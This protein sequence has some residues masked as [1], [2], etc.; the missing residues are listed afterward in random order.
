ME[1]EYQHEHTSS[2]PRYFPTSKRERELA[3]AIPLYDERE[4]T[5]EGYRVL[6]RR[7]R[8][9]CATSLAELQAI[10]VNNNFDIYL[11]KLYG[12]RGFVWLREAINSGTFTAFIANSSRQL[13]QL[14]FRHGRKTYKFIAV[15]NWGS[16]AIIS[17][18]F[19]NALY[20]VQEAYG[21][22]IFASPASLGHAGLLASMQA[23]KVGRVH[24][25]S[26][27]LR[28]K[29]RKY[30]SGGRA[31][32]F[33]LA[34][35]YDVAY[36]ADFDNSYGTQASLG[37]PSSRLGK[38]YC[39]GMEDVYNNTLEV[40]SAYHAACGFCQAQITIPDGF[41]G[42]FSPFYTRRSDE[43]LEWTTEPGTYTGY[44]WSDMLRRC[45]EIGFSVQLGKCWLWTELDPF[46]AD[47]VQGLIRLRQYFKQQ[48]MDTE[49]KIV[50]GIIVSAIGRF[51]ISNET[52]TLQTQETRK[53]GDTRWL[54]LNASEFEPMVTPYYVRSVTDY[55]AN[56]L[57]Q[58]ASYI[59]M[60]NNLALYDKA[61]SEELAGNTV[62]STNYDAL[63]L[64]QY[65]LT[66]TTGM[67]VKTHKHF[68]QLGLRS[69]R[70]NLETK[71]PG[72]ERSKR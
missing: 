19:L 13:V 65:P 15:G 60:K 23:N 61:L 37:V 32:D 7:E 36:E 51:G 46:M 22:G 63:Y 21:H 52:L 64:E 56:H 35:M 62:I 1:E 59:I 26:H 53:E 72:V 49:E 67:K 5:I 45:E 24:R 38:V 10:A 25:P 29:L 41:G 31:D 40:L 8:W 20:N 11:S 44:W 16:N 58:V 48:F 3:F 27:M 68:Q 50:K 69:H 30:S 9:Y 71:R 39:I 42:K 18:D 47:W 14:S 6:D 28:E 55:N 4:E 54:D 66:G 33:H 57:S 70:S 34:S 2:W 12:T 43:S 17:L